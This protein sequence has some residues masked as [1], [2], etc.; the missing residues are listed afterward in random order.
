MVT[1]TW[2]S[3]RVRDPAGRP[4]KSHPVR[5]LAADL[6]DD[7]A[8]VQSNGFEPPLTLASTDP[9]P[10]GTPV[11]VLCSYLDALDGPRGPRLVSRDDAVVVTVR[12]GAG[13]FPNPPVQME[14]QRM[15]AAH[16][17]SGGP[18]L[19]DR[20]AVAMVEGEL[21]DG[22]LGT[23]PLYAVHLPLEDAPDAPPG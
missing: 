6:T 16:G 14:L 5:V 12:T 2:E 23:V 1:S 10:P 11:V 18:V 15:V 19:A 13:S 9:L 8:L 4:P 7:A 3:S 17:C 22:R 20:G 21:S